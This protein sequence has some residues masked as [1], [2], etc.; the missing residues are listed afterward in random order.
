MKETK[1]MIIDY[2][3]QYGFIIHKHGD[4]RADGSY[5]VEYCD[6]HTD[7]SRKAV[8]TGSYKDCR[9]YAKAHRRLTDAIKWEMKQF[10]SDKY[11]EYFVPTEEARIAIDV[12]YGSNPQAVYATLRQMAGQYTRWYI[13]GNNAVSY[14]NTAKFYYRV[15]NE[16]N[17]KFGGSL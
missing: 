6:V 15:A 5:T 1:D 2:G 17:K 14:L 8:F 16:Y 13:E 12:C 3:Y 9:K 10:I 4:L 11:R 7:N